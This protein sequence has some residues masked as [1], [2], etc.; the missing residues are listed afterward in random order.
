M[1]LNLKY[2][3]SIIDEI[4]KTKGLTIENCIADN[5][6]NNL[7]LFISKGL[8]EGEKQGTSRNLALS[9]IDEYLKE[10]DKDDLLLDITEQL[11]NDGFLSRALDV[12]A[13]R[14]L[15]AKKAK[16][17]VAQMKKM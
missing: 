12:Q 1:K 7:A 14:E 10:N 2:N 6:I 4:E 5:T 16:E 11:V 13:M 9:K 8:V 17:V 15:K 3:A